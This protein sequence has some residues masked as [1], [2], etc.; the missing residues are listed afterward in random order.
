[1]KRYLLGLVIIFLMASCSETP[2]VSIS[3]GVDSNGVDC[4][5]IATRSATYY[6]Q[7]QA[8]GFSSIIDKNGRDWVAYKDSGQPTFPVSA[9]SDFRGLPNLVWKGNDDGV[10]HPGFD[11][12]STMILSENQISSISTSG[13]WGYTW[14]F[15]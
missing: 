2:E 8:G 1:M 5:I 14:T 12:V 11:K 15:T 4:F 10:G 7:K 6:Y 9:A 13:K 3:E